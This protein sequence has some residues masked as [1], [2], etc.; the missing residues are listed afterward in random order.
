MRVR[1]LLA[2]AVTT[3]LAGCG[4]A[5]T[6]PHRMTPTGPSRDIT[7][8]SGYHIATR[9]DGSQYCE[10]D[11]SEGLAAPASTTTAPQG[12]TTTTPA[13]TQD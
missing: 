3:I 10:A 5:A 9:D 12:T 8:R 4:D 7:C 1:L 2:A 13:P 11:G 6:A